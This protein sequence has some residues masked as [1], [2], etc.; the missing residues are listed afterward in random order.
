MS[1]DAQEA[2]AARITT[3]R[4]TGNVGVLLDDRA[5]IEVAVLRA[6]MGWPPSGPLP[7]GTDVRRGLDAAVTAGTF[8]WL[9]SQVLPQPDRLDELLEAAELLTAARQVAPRSVPRPVARM[10]ATIT[11]GTRGT[12]HAQ[13]HDEAI[14]VLSAGT[15]SGELSAI[16]HAI[17]LLA[18]AA[19]A[20]HGDRYQ[21]Y[22]LSDLGS[23]WLGRFA[24]TGRDQDLDHAV[25]AHEQ[26]AAGGVPVPEDRAG[27]LANYSAA[28]LARFGHGGD[29]AQLDRA[30]TIARTA[31]DLAR[32]AD[33]PFAAAPVAVEP[34]PAVPAPAPPPAGATALDESA[35]GTPAPTAALPDAVPPATWRSGAERP[36]A[37]PSAAAPVVAIPGP[38]S[39][40]AAAIRLAQ[41]SSLSRLRAALL[42]A[43]EQGGPEVDLD[44]AVQV[45]QEAVSL[46]PAS[47]PAYPRY[48]ASLAHLLHLQAE[49]RASPDPAGSAADIALPAGA[50]P[51]AGAQAAAAGPP[52]PPDE[53]WRRWLSAG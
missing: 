31:T 38:A 40:R 49:R 22:Y 17:V 11:G 9:R 13:V 10:L 37:A 8:L 3:F 46:V 29:R 19:R 5:L 25:A 4:A 32:T 28:L 51:G 43:Y 27:L 1:G 26:A 45:A 36:D 16:D 34:P 42:A 21:P 48:Q 23:A 53:P 41:L 20:A 2:L 6:A 15:R 24:I 39:E 50:P 14:D 35:T 12:D 47:D 44:E 52:D 7:P 33:Q 30:I 18:T